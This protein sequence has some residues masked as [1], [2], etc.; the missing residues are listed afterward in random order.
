M[1]FML[2]YRQVIRRDDKHAGGIGVE[3]M[4]LEPIVVRGVG[5][6]WADAGF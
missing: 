4:A 1:G 3:P 5:S 6:N 2:I